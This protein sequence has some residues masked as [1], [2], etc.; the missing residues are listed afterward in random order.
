MYFLRD[1]ILSENV[2]LFVNSLF[3]DFL[4]L[5]NLFSVFLSC[6]LKQEGIQPDSSTVIGKE[7]V[8]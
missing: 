7:N 4:L 6:G 3:K 1:K 5:N 2:K 8:K